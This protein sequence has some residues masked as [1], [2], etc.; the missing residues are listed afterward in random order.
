MA[1]LIFDDGFRANVGIVIFNQKQ[2]VFFAKRRYQSGWQFPQ[3]GIQL[4]ESPKKAMFRELLEET[5]L[6]KKSVEIIYV[7][8][9]WYDYRI[10]KKSIR[11]PT[12]GTTVIGQRQKWFLL[13]LKGRSSNISLAS[14]PEQEFDSWKWIDP[15][16]SIN[17][18]IGFKKEVYKQVIDEFMPFI[19][20]N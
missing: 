7:S 16:T 3:G 10:P 13:K 17:Q 1:D 6:D 19:D 9:Y 11:K 12:N 2:Q 18:V 15:E 5:G 8:D 14:S 4:G 20:G